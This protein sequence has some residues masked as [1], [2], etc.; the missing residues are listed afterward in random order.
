MTTGTSTGSTMDRFR[1]DGRVVA[2]TGAA[3]LLGRRFAGALADAGAS[4]VL[5]DLE[6]P[7]TTRLEIAGRLAPTA[8]ALALACDV[9]DDASVTAARDA[10]EAT[11]GP[12]SGLVNAAAI[13]S[14]PSTEGAGTDGP[15]ATTSSAA[16]AAALDVNLEG[17]VRCCRILGA[18]MAE[19][20][21]GAIVNI[22]SH[23]GIVGPDQRMYASLREAGQDFH[24]PVAYTVAKAGVIGLTRYLAG[25]W[26]ADGVRV[27]TL[28][29]G[30]AFDD[31][32]PGFVAAYASRTPM[33]RMAHADEYDAAVVFLLSDAASYMTGANLVIDGGFTA[34]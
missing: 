6:A 30:G 7:E 23:Y 16:I 20:G 14:V 5:L 1:L 34:W 26:G 10:A 24:K 22:A 9:R 33:G 19:R 27:N 8:G 28:S 15:F 12:L 2:I 32:D 18:P 17:V 29:P 21:R 13:N 25:Y 11:L 4:L 31:Q 3:G